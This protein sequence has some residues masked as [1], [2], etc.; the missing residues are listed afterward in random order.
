MKS[1]V[2]PI[3]RLIQLKQQKIDLDN[4]VE[5]AQFEAIAYH[6]TQGGK[7]GKVDV[8]N[9]ASFTFK[10]VPRKPVPTLDIKQKIEWAEEIE[11]ELRISNQLRIDVLEAQ[12]RSLVTSEEAIKLRKEA[13]E[14]LAVLPV[15]KVPQIATS[16]PKAK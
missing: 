12:L 7:S 9:G 14:M 5:E 1:A 11:K 10:Y 8:G 6:L 15:E 4:L 3:T 2:N 16:L 13:E